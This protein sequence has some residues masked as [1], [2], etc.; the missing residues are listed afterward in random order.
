MYPLGIY[1]VA[2]RYYW[3]DN[4]GP[5]YYSTHFTVDGDNT[6][7]SLNSEAKYQ[8]SYYSLYRVPELTSDPKLLV[9]DPQH[10]Y[11]AVF[12]K[13]LPELLPAFRLLKLPLIV[14]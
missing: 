2:H 10:A 12:S 14:T 6:C 1:G 9:P 3:P 5:F 13:F 7:L 8:T 4:N 11:E